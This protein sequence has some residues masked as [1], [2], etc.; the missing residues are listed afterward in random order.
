MHNSP[1]RMP[2]R[3]EGPTV[4]TRAKQVNEK[5]RTCGSVRNLYPEKRHLVCVRPGDKSASGGRKP[6]IE[7]PCPVARAIPSTCSRSVILP[8][9][10]MLHRPSG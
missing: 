7:S 5:P 1:Q 9:I 3:G 2:C 10:S 4:F 8:P 6:R